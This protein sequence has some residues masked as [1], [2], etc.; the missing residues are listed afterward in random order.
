MGNISS[1]SQKIEPAPVP[2]HVKNTKKVYNKFNDWEGKR[3]EKSVKK[4]YTIV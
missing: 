1:A 3:I 4:E 2:P